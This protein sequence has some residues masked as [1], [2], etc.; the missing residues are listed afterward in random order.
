MLEQEEEVEKV[1]WG[2][3]NCSAFGW[4]AFVYLCEAS[5][6]PAGLC[7]LRFD[8][9]ERGEGNKT[10]RLHLTYCMYEREK[11]IVKNQTQPQLSQV[12][13][14]MCPISRPMACLFQ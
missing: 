13:V 6:Q 4:K 12:C 2:D 14:F 10:R 8:L 1:G 7:Y 3:V 11:G 5:F 9:W